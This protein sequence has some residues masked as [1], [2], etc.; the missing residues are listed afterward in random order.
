MLGIETSCDETSF[1]LVESGYRLINYV[2]GSSAEIHARYGGIIPEIASR[3]HLE[4]L[5]PLLNDLFS[6]CTYEP[7][8]I[9]LIAVT[10][11]P[12]LVPSL[13]VGVS[14]GKAFSLALNRPLVGVDHILA[15]LYA[16]FIDNP[17]PPELPFVG[18]VISGGHTQILWVSDWHKESIEVLGR[19]RDDAVGEAL[20]KASKMLGLGYPG[21]PVIERMAEGGESIYEFSVYRGDD[22][23]FSFSGVKT[24][25]FYFL[26]GRRLNEKLLKDVCA[27]YQKAVMEVLVEKTIRAGMLKSVKDIVVG[28]GVSANRYLRR[29]LSEE[30][31]RC[32]LRVHFPDFSLCLDNAVMI[33]GLGY[34][35]YIRGI[36]DDMALEVSGQSEWAR[37][38]LKMRR[39]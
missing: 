16:S 1:A 20:D 14:T 37:K 15:H 9:D 33:A 32:G 38:G 23:D 5:W 10:N 13:L 11:R 39:E 25:L 2:I 18:L 34:Q 17:D 6:G 31:G 12:G 36:K 28:G 35:W 8:D 22:L 24:S 3:K 19:T 26:K 21:G 27:S 4:L 29:R 7:E 30:A